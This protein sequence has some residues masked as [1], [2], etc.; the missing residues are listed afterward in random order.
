[1]PTNSYHDWLRVAQ[2]HSRRENET[3]DLLHDAL[4]AAV[5]AG[6][7]PLEN[8]D[9]GPWFYGVIA[10]QA[11]M[12]ARTGVRERKCR[13]ALPPP[14][15]KEA[16]PVT[17]PGIAGL[18]DALSP[19]L[20]RVLVLCLHGLDRAEIRQVL[21]IPDTALRQRLSAL[22]KATSLCTTTV[23]PQS[24]ALAWAARLKERNP[25]DTGLRRATLARGPS[26]I[27]GFRFGFSDADGNVI[28]VNAPSASQNPQ[29]RQ[30][31]EGPAS[32]AN[33]K[34]RK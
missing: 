2:R 18:L 28:A 7:R 17:L 19:G 14:E 9:D 4:L 33:P 31:V 25:Q 16:T 10:Q 30:Q 8:A 20:R 11:T 23:D 29:D 12:R 26:R 6:R 34:P 3:E 22:R 27:T 32:D 13:D 1:M 15:D 21:G 24:I 5:L